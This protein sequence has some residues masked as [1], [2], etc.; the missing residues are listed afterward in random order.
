MDPNSIQDQQNLIFNFF[1]SDFVLGDSDLFDSD[2][3]FLHSVPKT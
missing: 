1:T 2:V 3:L